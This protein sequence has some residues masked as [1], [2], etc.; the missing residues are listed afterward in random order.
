MHGFAPEPGLICGFLE[1]ASGALEPLQ[2][3]GIEQALGSTDGFVWLHFDL[4]DARVQRWIAQ[5][6]TLPDGARRMLLTEDEHV[7]LK[8]V[9]RGVAGVVNDL[10][11]DFSGDPSAVGALRLYFDESRFVTARRQPLQAVD[12]LRR[13][14]Q[15]GPCSRRPLPLL[16]SLLHH[17]CD[18]FVGLMQEATDDLDAVEA[19]ILEHDGDG[20]PSLG[21]VRRLLARLRRH[22]GPQR[23]ALSALAARPPAWASEDDAAALRDAVHRLEAVGHDLELAQERGRQLH[24]ERA[25]RLAEITNRNLYFLSIVTALFLPMTLITGVFGMNVGGLPGV[26]QPHGFLWTML[27]MGGTGAATFV[28]LK[29]ARIV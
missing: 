25:A 19:S 29:L 14:M 27:L 3:D 26:E 13:S 8:P 28:L 24:D 11:H 12:R 22:L 5:T 16:S 2:W 21:K 10:H 6:E 20:D 18:A 15:D 4:A 9:G 17:L 23:L 1:R 7:R